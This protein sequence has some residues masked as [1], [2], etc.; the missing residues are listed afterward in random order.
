MRGF[1]AAAAIVVFGFVSC[2]LVL[3]HLFPREQPYTPHEA[4]LVNPCTDDPSLCDS[5]QGK[6]GAPDGCPNQYHQYAAKDLIGCWGSSR[7]VGFAA[8]SCTAGSQGVTCKSYSRELKHGETF[9]EPDGTVIT[10]Y[11]EPAR[12]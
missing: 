2:Q 10:Y 8:Q 5:T 11:S 6:D 1:I 9:T 7:S 3:N 12:R 4:H